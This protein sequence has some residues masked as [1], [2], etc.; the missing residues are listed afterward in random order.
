[1]IIDPY[2][3]NKIVFSSD[4]YPAS[5]GL[6]V[7]NVL[8]YGFGDII[9]RSSREKISLLIH[10]PRIDAPRIIKEGEEFYINL[11]TQS[12]DRL[13]GTRGME[14]STKKIDVT[15]TKLGLGWVTM[16]RMLAKCLTHGISWLRLQ[17]GGKN[18]LQR[19]IIVAS[20]RK[21]DT[22]TIA[23]YSFEEDLLKAARRI[24]KILIPN[25][26]SNIISIKKTKSD[27]IYYISNTSNYFVRPQVVMKLE[28]KEIK[29]QIIFIKD[30]SL[31]YELS[32]EYYYSYRDKLTL[33]IKNLSQVSLQITFIG[34]E[35]IGV[36]P[37]PIILS[38]KSTKKI[39]LD[40]IYQPDNFVEHLKSSLKIIYKG[41]NP[42]CIQ[43]PLE[44]GIINKTR[45]KSLVE[46]ILSVKKNIKQAIRETSERIDLPFDVIS[47]IVKIRK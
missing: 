23:V 7:G 33:A 19:Q 20:N 31:E 5:M 4:T 17:R 45:V 22:S 2:K 47:R 6:K 24:Q 1:M 36:P 39:N 3:K 40:I 16:S 42:H 37:D 15:R 11:I 32:D 30:Q 38:P 41:S 21:I 27:L 35:V 14:I 9:Y 46:E 43:I 12:K 34:D 8:G 25:N 10:V 29:Q 13:I 44:L 28:D 18:I 26:K